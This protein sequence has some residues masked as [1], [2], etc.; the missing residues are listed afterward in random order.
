MLLKADL[1]G[2][3][4]HVVCFLP[5]VDTVVPVVPVVPHVVSVVQQLVSKALV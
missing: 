1:F 3:L 2:L 5:H 4:V